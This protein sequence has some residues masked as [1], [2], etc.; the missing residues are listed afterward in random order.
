MRRKEIEALIERYDEH[1]RYGELTQ[2]DRI[3]HWLMKKVFELTKD[4]KEEPEPETKKIDYFDGGIAN[5]APDPG[6]WEQD[7]AGN[8][9]WVEPAAEVAPVQPVAQRVGVGGV[10]RNWRNEFI[11]NLAR[12]RDPVPVAAEQ[13]PRE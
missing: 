11:Q 8:V 1:E 3:T 2:D 6:W 10:N 4:E 9:R 5:R 7:A 13:E 12:F